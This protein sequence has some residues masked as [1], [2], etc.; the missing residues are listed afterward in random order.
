MS[1][2]IFLPEKTDVM[3]RM[4]LLIVLM[5]SVCL[6]SAAQNIS[7]MD[8]IM[9]LVG[10]GSPEDVDEYEVERLMILLERP[11]KINHVSS[12]RLVAGGLLNA[13]QAASL[14]DYR[15]RHGDV[16][17]FGELAAI[18]GFSEAF[19]ENIKPFISLEGGN[20]GAVSGS[21]LWNDLAVRAGI[22][23]SEGVPMQWNYGLR[24][25]VE[26]ACGISAGIA[27]SRSASAAGSMPDSFSGSLEWEARKLPVRLIVGDYNARFGQGLALWN[28]MSMSGL[29]S[30]STF[31]RRASGYSRS[32]SFTGGL[33]M[34]GA[35]VSVRAGHLDLNASVALP[36][37]RNISSEPDEM[38][39]LPAFNMQWNHRSGQ[40]GMTH[41][42]NL[43]PFD[44]R[45]GDGKT[46][47]DAAWCIRGTDVFAESSFDWMAKVPAALAGVSF[48]VGELWRSAVMVR[49]YPASY[50][51]AWSGAQR[52]TTSCSDEFS[53][54]MAAEYLSADRTDIIGIS[55]DAAYFP[56]PKDKA[57]E[58]NRQMKIEA[59]WE[60]L[61]DMFVLKLRAKE[62]IRDWGRTSRTDLRADLSFSSGPVV[63]NTR[64]NLLYCIGL[65]GL[66]YVECGYKTSS[67][68]AYLKTGIFIVD[69]W[70]DRIYSYE[71]D[72]PGSFNVPAFYGRGVWA[73]AVVSW[74]FARWGKVYARAAYTGYPF[75]DEEKK[76]PG[77]AEL[78]LQCMFSF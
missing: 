41:Y 68:S 62:R 6:H 20:I 63:V 22:K 9:R 18:D 10:A 53:A 56:Q 12:S 70:D 37:I 8:A 73:S 49:A 26:S 30:P 19:V 29:T 78:R 31:M 75:M 35:A 67:L 57:D 74:K 14:A 69:N 55:V 27:A 39:V 58:H 36:G 15:M 61:T 52:S 21:G 17:S 72:A 47:I 13:Y 59:A 24:Y 28:G 2:G 71:R 3:W 43:N 51:S 11:L 45:I 76:K 46:S 60:H 23:P 65:S 4:K 34:T 16:L 25:S 54:T 50:S 5:F 44:G 32:S 33:A 40:V 48:P 1:W 7:D 64:A 66:A 42:F 77:R 38:S